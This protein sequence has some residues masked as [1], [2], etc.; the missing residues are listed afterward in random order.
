MTSTVSKT[1]DTDDAGRRRRLAT[2]LGAG[3]AAAGAGAAIAVTVAAPASAQ[4]YGSY[5]LSPGFGDC[6]P[7]Q[8]ASYQVR[9]D[10]WATGEGAKFKLLKNGQ[11]VI[12][13]PFRATA[14][15]FELRSS[16][17]TFPG[18]GNYT[19]CAQ[20][21]GTKNTIATMQLRTDWEF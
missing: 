2:R 8:Y 7:S 15:A 20:N 16:N 1:T 11:V 9:A 18:P 5:P 21:T 12:N 13:T 4:Q 14:G 17:Y 19:V 10:F 6:T 3:L